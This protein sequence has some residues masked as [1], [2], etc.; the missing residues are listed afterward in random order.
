[1]YTRL[2]T[3]AKLRVLFEAGP[4]VDKHKTGV[5]YFVDYLVQSLAKT[6]SVDLTGYYF[7][8]LG[9]NKIPTPTLKNTHFERI[10]L[11]PGKTLSEIGRAHV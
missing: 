7:D 4:M 5:G 10:S 8:F 1:M 2:Q 6:D 11:I 3:M 9:K